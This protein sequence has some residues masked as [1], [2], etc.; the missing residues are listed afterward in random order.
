MVSMLFRNLAAMVCWFVFLLGAAAVNVWV[1]LENYLSSRTALEL[2]R[3]D[4]MPLSVDPLLGPYIGIFFPQLTLHVTTA[5][6]LALALSVGFFFI[7]HELFKLYALARQFDLHRSAGNAAEARALAWEMGLDALVLALIAA[8]LCFWALPLNTELI[9]YRSVVSG[10]LGITDPAVAA[11]QA[12]D[13]ETV[14]ARY[15]NLFS[16]QIAALAPWGVMAITAVACLAL[17]VA[18][19]K[20]S[21]RFQRLCFCIENLWKEENAAEQPFRA[22]READEPL[23][24]ADAAG[25][26]DRD[27]R[28][29]PTAAEPADLQEPECTAPSAAAEKGAPEVI[30]AEPGEGKEEDS[31]VE[32]ATG[33]RWS[34]RLWELLHPERA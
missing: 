13:W 31:I 21:N 4:D 15:G 27:G 7:M 19:V 26:F 18:Y 34:R 23:H 24:E 14:R 25:R 29:F 16:V 1:A 8:V 2:L 22:D 20:F 11:V 10:A 17:E 30:G 33:R 9:K 12:P 6:S 5:M 28:P 3:W 32:P